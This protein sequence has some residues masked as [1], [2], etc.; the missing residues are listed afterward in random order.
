[1]KRLLYIIFP[2]AGIFFIVTTAFTKRSNPSEEKVIPANSFHSGDIILRE[3]HGMLGELFKSFSLNERKFSH[4]G[5]INSVNGEICVSH[6]TDEQKGVVCEKLSVFISKDKCKSFAIFRPKYSISQSMSIKQIINDP[7]NRLIP[8]DSKF[9]LS[10][11]DAMYC[12]EWVYKC[13]IKV[14]IHTPLTQ[15]KGGV[16]IAPDNLYINNLVKKIYEASY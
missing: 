11:D 9:D 15:S 1:M 14:D 10:S 6:F 13:L 8:F 12:T 7:G 3:S 2:L 16:Y 4:A 5:F